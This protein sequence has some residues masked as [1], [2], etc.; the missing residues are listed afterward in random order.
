MT[1]LVNFAE[2]LV[3]KNWK[4]PLADEIFFLRYSVYHV[5]VYEVVIKIATKGQRPQLGD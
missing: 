5:K 4:S 3:S 2:A 1:I